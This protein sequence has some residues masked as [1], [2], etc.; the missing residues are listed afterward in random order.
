MTDFKP[1]IAIEGPDRVG[2]T[3]LIQK[4]KEDSDFKDW[5]FDSA[6][7]T[8]GIS[9]KCRDILIENHAT[10]SHDLQSALMDVARADML[11]RAEATGKSGLISDRG[12][13]STLVYQNQSSKS[14]RAL[15]HNVLG[16][17]YSLSFDDMCWPRPDYKSD[18]WHNF[19]RPLTI[20]L[21]EDEEVMLERCRLEQINSMDEPVYQ[22]EIRGRYA[23]L[24]KTLSDNLHE[25]FVVLK[26]SD[27]S[28]M[29]KLKEAY[30]TYSSLLNKRH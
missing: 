28:I 13:M 2:K 16:S 29:E 18:H 30:E 10:T 22:T 11:E 12:F 5:F 8:I 17:G 19:G 23:V 7:S 24:S 14:I 1:W 20:I 21:W 6:T 25:Y 27:P 15:T 3:T 26:A 9:G 4:L